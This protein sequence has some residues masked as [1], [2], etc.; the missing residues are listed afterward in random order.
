MDQY[1]RSNAKRTKT[2]RNPPKSADQPSEDPAVKPARSNERLARELSKYKR[3][4]PPRAIHGQAAPGCEGN[5]QLRQETSSCLRQETAGRARRIARLMAMAS[6]AG[7]RNERRR[8]RSTSRRKM[9]R[10]QQSL[11][12]GRLQQVRLGVG[13][14]NSILGALTS[15]SSPWGRATVLEYSGAWRAS[16]MT[17]LGHGWTT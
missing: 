17:Y 15:A 6:C 8:R 16:W 4:V 14:H 1:T 7:K 10:R 3:P 9:A 13:V 5:I 11:P 2:F 12:P